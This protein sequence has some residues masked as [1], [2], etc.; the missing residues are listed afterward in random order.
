M[1]VCQ[2]FVISENLDGEG[3]SVEIV[4]PGL[5]GMADHKEF[6]VIDVIVLFCRNEQLGE[7]GTGVLITVGVSLEKDGTRGIL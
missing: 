4:L 2:V 5:Q 3:G 7:V 6:L 1:E